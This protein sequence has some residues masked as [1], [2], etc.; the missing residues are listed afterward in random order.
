MHTHDGFVLKFAAR[1]VLTSRLYRDTANLSHTK[2][3][4]EE[5]QPDLVKVHINS[6][7]NKTNTWGIDT[8]WHVYATQWVGLGL[9]GRYISYVRE[10][11]VLYACQSPFL[12][13]DITS[14]PFYLAYLCIFMRLG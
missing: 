2:A 4:L 1:F 10:N 7:A 6:T 14:F 3:K 12:H 5:C 8:L 13:I 11:C 9:W